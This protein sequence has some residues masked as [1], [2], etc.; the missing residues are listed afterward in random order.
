MDT[1]NQL[2]ENIDITKGD[3]VSIIGS[4]G[5]TTLLRALSK[6]LAKDL[7]VAAATTTK[8][9]YP[10]QEDLTR[11]MI[12]PKNIPMHIDKAGVYYFANEHLGG[13]LIGL[14]E[15]L[16]HAAKRLTDIM[17]IEADGSAGKPLKGWADY[18]PVVVDETTITIGV[19][20]ITAIGQRMDDKTVHR[21]PIFLKLVDE[22]RGAV[23]NWQHLIH[24][25]NHQDGLFK[26]AK[27]KR[28]LYI[29]QAKDEKG[30]LMSEGI[31][32]LV[33]TDISKIVI[34]EGRG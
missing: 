29:S 26:K 33:R 27:G 4:G 3:V 6:A 14:G 20:P 21:L 5:K 16:R 18:E 31:V 10:N 12:G 30:V 32:S 25:I 22:Q 1:I 9:F 2:I 15:E 7:R 8:I 19:I 24:V 28:V 17:V 34:G 23:I 11:V 13:K